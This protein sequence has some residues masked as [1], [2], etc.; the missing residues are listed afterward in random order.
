M[1]NIQTCM[2]FPMMHLQTEAHREGRCPGPMTVLKGLIARAEK[3]DS[4]C[5]RQKSELAVTVC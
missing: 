3:E 2:G 4:L 5:T 1:L